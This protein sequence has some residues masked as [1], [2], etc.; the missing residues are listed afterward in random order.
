MVKAFNYSTGFIGVLKFDISYGRM[1]ICSACC[2]CDWRVKTEY[3]PIYF[4]ISLNTL[5][6]RCGN[7][8]EIKSLLLPECF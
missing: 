6:E 8:R 3:V 7:F 1:Y 4:V 5:R 2:Y